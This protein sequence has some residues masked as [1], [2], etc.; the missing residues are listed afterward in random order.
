MINDLVNQRATAAAFEYDY[1]VPLTVINARA[2]SAA[3]TSPS[4]QPS[5]YTAT[6][7]FMGTSTL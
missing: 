1:I 4:K 2:Q 7:W 3:N 6:T 5:T